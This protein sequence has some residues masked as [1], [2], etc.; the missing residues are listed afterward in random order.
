M[1]K[2]GLLAFKYAVQ[3]QLVFNLTCI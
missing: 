1:K 3:F 2:D